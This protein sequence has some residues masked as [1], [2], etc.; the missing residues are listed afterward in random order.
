MA[1]LVDKTCPV[2]G[3]VFTISVGAQEKLRKTCSRP[4]F[5]KKQRREKDVSIFLRYT[6]L[7]TG[8]RMWNGGTG[9][10]GYGHV[11]FNGKTREI[12]RVVLEKKLGRPLTT[13]EYALHTCDTPGCMNEEHLYSPLEGRPY[14][15]LTEGQKRKLSQLQNIGK[16]AK[17]RNRFPEGERHY[18]AMLTNE[19]ARHVKQLQYEGVSGRAIRLLYPQLSINAL[20]LIKNGWTWRHIL[21]PDGSVTE[22]DKEDITA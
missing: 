8:C 16:D 18:K 22:F 2:C 10:G 12:T 13:G 9:Y 14:E 7:E 4:C 6:Q 5:Y 3:T 19:E 20:S 1:N 21:R 11:R 15:A 17:E